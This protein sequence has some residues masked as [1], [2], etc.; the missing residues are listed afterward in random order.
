MPTN[1]P[2]MRRLPP[3]VPLRLELATDAG[4]TDIREFKLCFTVNAA[5][6]IKEKTR[7][8]DPSSG[9]IID[10]GVSLLNFIEAW[11]QISDPRLLRVMFWA[12]VLCHHPE[13]DT[14][15]ED[16][17]LTDEGID[18][19]GTLI[20]ETVSDQIGEALWQAYLKSLSKTKREAVIKVREMAEKQIQSQQGNPPV[21]PANENPS[22]AASAT[23][24][25]K[26]TSGSNSTPSPAGLASD[27][28]NSAA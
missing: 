23:D 14:R 2:L 19:I 20:D 21:P 11:S 10:P 9:K 4:M 17:R 27:Q 15:D 6:A 7:I 26:T 16:G 13:Y 25:T 3:S 1:S 5:A 8:V 22:G 24:S 12:A 28:K 18:T